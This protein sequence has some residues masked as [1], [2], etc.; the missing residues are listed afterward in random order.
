MIDILGNLAGGFGI[1]FTPMAVVLCLLGVFAGITFGAIPGIS[2]SMA[3]ALLL[4]MTFRLD[5][6][7][8]MVLLLGAYKGANYGGSV[9]AVLINT[10]GTPSAAVTAFDGYPMTKTGRVGEAMGISLFASVFGGIIGTV[11]LILFAQPLAVVAL[12]FWPSEYFALTILGLT[13]VATMGGKNWQKALVAVVFGLLL[14]T[15]GMDPIA[16]TQRFTFGEIRLLDGLSLIPAIIGLFALGELF[17]NIEHY[18]KGEKFDKLAYK[19]PKLRSYLKVWKNITRAGVLG[20]LIGIFPG[21]GGTIAAFISYDV[22]KRF[23][24]NP[25]EFGKGS[26]EGVAAAESSNSASAGGALVPLLA[27]GI[28]GSATAAVLLGS[29]LVHGL[30]PGPE[31]FIDEP[32]LVYGMFASMFM[33]NA[34]ILLVGLLGAGLFVRVTDLKKTILYPL[35][36]TFAIVGSYAVSSSMYPVVVCVA[37]GVIGWIFRRYDFPCAPVVLGIVLGSLAELSFRQ[38]LI[39][40]GIESFYKRPLT[41]IMLAIAI[42]AVAAPIVKKRRDEKKLEKVQD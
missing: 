33:A 34:F 42:A 36:F 4:P 2:P 9:S 26:P 21:A 40:G 24:K 17:H 41:L 15:I 8:G 7:L 28:P 39:I 5:P 20:T 6:I 10:P 22:E 30:N 23:S 12:E 16:G 18:A 13:T 19:L 3:V 27:L 37:F 14:N 31:M 29:L 38:A 11:V 35:I 1:M 25:E 32:E